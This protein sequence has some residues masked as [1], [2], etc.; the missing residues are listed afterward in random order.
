MAAVW[1][2]THCSTLHDIIV[3]DTHRGVAQ[4]IARAVW[5]REVAGLNP[6]TPTKRKKRLLSLFFLLDE[7]RIQPCDFLPQTKIVAGLVQRRA[8][9]K[10]PL[11]I[12]FSSKRKR[13]QPLS[14]SDTIY[15][16]I[17]RAII[18]I[19]TNTQQPSHLSRKRLPT[20]LERL[21]IYFW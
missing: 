12:L 18:T 10:A 6:V 14:C 7:L 4:L 11:G 15:R 5:D 3:T 1:A 8:E 20:F 17:C 21:V 2:Q 19:C 9:N 16:P 13:P